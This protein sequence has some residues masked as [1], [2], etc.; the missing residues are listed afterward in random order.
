[1]TGG[2]PYR[3]QLTDEQALAEL[4]ER[5]GTQFDPACVQALAAVVRERSRESAATVG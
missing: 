3:P 1:M 2:R 4:S 5:S